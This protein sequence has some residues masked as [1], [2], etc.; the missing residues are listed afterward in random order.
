[1]YPYIEFK[2]KHIVELSNQLEMSDK[3]NAKL[4]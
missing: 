3:I 4:N 2:N 1:M